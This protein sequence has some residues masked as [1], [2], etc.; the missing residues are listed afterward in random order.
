MANPALQATHRLQAQLAPP[1][2]GGASTSLV[3]CLS[4]GV[5][6]ADRQ[7]TVLYASG[8]ALA[9][10]GMRAADVLGKWLEPGIPEF[11]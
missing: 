11:T 8:P 2:G 4:E 3:E 1:T 7:G 6:T 5:I 9:M 10:I